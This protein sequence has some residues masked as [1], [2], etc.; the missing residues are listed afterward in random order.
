M[1]FIK[2]TK[3]ISIGI[4]LYLGCLLFR[5]PAKHFYEINFIEEVNTPILAD[6]FN[7]GIT[8]HYWNIIER[9]YN[10]NNELQYYTKENVTV[11]N[12]Y[13]TITAQKEPYKDHEYTSGLLTTQGKFEFLYGKVIF[14]AKP[15]IGQ[16]LLSAVW[17]LPADDS[18]F[19]EIDIIEV[20]GSEPYEI[21][22]GVH[23]LNPIIVT[24]DFNKY[25]KSNDGFSTYELEWNKNEIKWYIDGNL[26]H[27][28][29]SG[30]PNTPMYLLINLAVG[31][32]WP[33]NPDNKDLPSDF[34]IDYIIII[35]EKSHQK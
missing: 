10:Y 11:E 28:T 14:K 31:G 27:Q 12:G 20:L 4:L 22:T 1:I 33:K 2:V 32:D 3:L 6:N 35:P 34:L 19:P 29:K 26:V 25:S 13:L 30:V 18:L 7:K 15:A 16:G 23:Y 9:G 17:L 21:W 24:S 8:P 5:E